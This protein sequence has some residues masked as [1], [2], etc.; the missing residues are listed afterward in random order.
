MRILAG[1][2]V[3]VLLGGC[4]STP[5]LTPW[6]ADALL[7]SLPADCAD[8]AAPASQT[9]LSGGVP[10]GLAVV[11]SEG[12]DVILVAARSCVWTV[13]AQT[14]AAAPLPTHG[15]SI[16]PTMIDAGRAGLAFSSSLSG[17]VRTIDAAGAV[18]LNVSGLRQPLGTRLLPGG[19]VLVAEHGTG[20]ILRL[21]PSE[22][23]RPRLVADGLDGPTGLV[24]VDA[25]HG[26]VTEAGS[27]RVTLVNL[28]HPEQRAIATGLEQPEGIAVLSDGRLAVAEVGARRLVA[29]DP[30]T[31]A[32]EVLADHLPIG[33]ATPQDNADLHAVTDVAATP[34]GLIVISAAGDRTILK[35]RRRAPPHEE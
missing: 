20:R 16:A 9:A 3:L 5:E 22:E 19:I 2:P 18:V 27:G 4:A 35:L 23:S 14:G 26:Y 29:V 33:P 15:D 7:P 11:H 13:D 30:R 28:G 24:V 10:G 17:S 12:R 8:S 21:G 1:L 32:V 31:G 25:T 34:A 6:Q